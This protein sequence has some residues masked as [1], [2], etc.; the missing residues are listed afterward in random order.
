[1]DAMN[2]VN[3]MTLPGSLFLLTVAF[4]I[5]ISRIG[6]PY[7]ALLF[8]VHKL[9]ALGGAVLA[10]VRMLGL[11]P[12]VYFP[13]AAILCLI[14]AAFS[15]LALFVT[16]ALMSIQKEES[17]LIKGIHQISPVVI[18]MA[19]LGGVYLLSGMAR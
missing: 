18:A 12:L 9:I 16:G 10:L 15:I 11:N 19:A 2:Y 5:W 17:R 14:L 1:M 8:N 6:R 13:P 7:H 3:D 4:G